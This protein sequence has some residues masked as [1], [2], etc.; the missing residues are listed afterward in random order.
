MTPS[1]EWAGVSTLGTCAPAQ[2]MRERWGQ[3]A[4]LSDASEGPYRAFHFL[5]AAPS[6]SAGSGKRLGIP[7]VGQRQ[8]APHHRFEFVAHRSES[9][10]SRGA[11]R[12]H[13]GSIR[14]GP[15]P[16]GGC[17]HPMRCRFTK[18]TFAAEGRAPTQSNTC[19]GADRGRT[20]DLL[21]AIQ[22]LSQL[23]YSPT[24]VADLNAEMN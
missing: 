11:R 5:R 8:N 19:G 7:W 13:S 1:Y 18:G 16:A 24:V 10:P 17:R 12:R 14:P 4:G 6:E 15:L 3:L 23:S 21:N 2:G 9:R 20:D 22:A